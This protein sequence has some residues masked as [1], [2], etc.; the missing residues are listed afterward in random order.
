MCSIEAID[1]A[2]VMCSCK[3]HVEL[4]RAANPDLFALVD[5]VVCGSDPRIKHGKPHPDIFLT[6]A[7]DLGV[8][9]KKCW[10][11]EDAPAG[12]LSAK[13]AGTPVLTASVALP[14]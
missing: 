1:I 13:A 4:K 10:A 11:F 14:V 2:S 5:V 7:E 12:V 6:A 3:E 8:D 9:P